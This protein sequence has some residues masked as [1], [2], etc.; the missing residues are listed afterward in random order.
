[1]IK[2]LIGDLFASSSQT[3]VNTVNCVGV[4]GKGVALE[5]KK[6]FPEL[7]EDYIARCDRK[8]VRI[9]EPY[10]FR[11]GR[12]RSVL[13]FPTKNHW[14]SPSR[15]SDIEQGLDYFL[16]HYATWN[17]TSIAFPPLGCGNGGLDWSEVGPLLYGRLRNL[18]IAIELYAPYGTP[19]NELTEAF[20]GG[21]SQLSLEGRGRT[22]EKMNPDWV[23]LI[24]VLRELDAQPY[25]PPV[26][27]VIF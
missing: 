22:F 3:L 6:R 10:L 15:L 13:N 9:G 16:N 7:F 4:M 8:Q 19:K 27:R 12:D 23:V 1:M 2:V 24:E 20:L 25:A 26:G 14:R 5:F 11:L 18:P 17:I 21:P